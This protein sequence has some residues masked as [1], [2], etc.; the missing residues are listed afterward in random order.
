MA[1]LVDI[2]TGIVHCAVECT[3]SLFDLVASVVSSDTGTCY[4]VS[5]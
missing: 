1:S 4:T 3:R 2:T 5:V